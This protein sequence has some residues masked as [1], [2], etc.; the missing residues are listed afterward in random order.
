MGIRWWVWVVCLAAIA[1]AFSPGAF[2]VLLAL[3]G[4]WA[5]WTALT[6]GAAVLVWR[7][8]ASR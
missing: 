4:P 5:L 7:K 6:V 1:I 3:I 2:I 8:V